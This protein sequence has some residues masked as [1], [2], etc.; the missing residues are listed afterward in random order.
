MKYLD[1]I[2]GIEFSCENSRMSYLHMFV[3]VNQQKL[4]LCKTMH[5]QPDIENIGQ[6]TYS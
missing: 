5:D 6:P 3:F 1:W 2:G 4:R